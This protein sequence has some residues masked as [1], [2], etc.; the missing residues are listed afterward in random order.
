[1]AYAEIQFKHPKTGSVCSA[2]VGFSW[3]TLFFG[4]CPALLRGHYTAVIAI[5]ILTLVIVDFSANTDSQFA[6]Y[7]LWLVL[8]FIY[9]K[10]YIKH[11]LKKGYKA[12][13]ASHDLEYLSGQ[14]NLIL[15]KIQE[16]DT[17][18]GNIKSSIFEKF[19]ALAYRKEEPSLISLKEW[20][21]RV[22]DKENNSL[23]DKP[24]D[25]KYLKEICRADSG[26]TNSECLM[27][28]MAWGYT[29]PRNDTH[30]A[31]SLFENPESVEIVERIIGELRRGE[32]WYLHAY[33][34]FY[35]A[36]N[37]ELNKIKGLGVA[38][39]TKLIFFCDPKH[40]GYIMDQFASKSV[41][42]LMDTEIVLITKEG[43][44]KKENTADNYEK[45]CDTIKS[46]ASR[47][48]WKPDEVELAL[49]SD[50]G[51][52]KYVEF[53]YPIRFHK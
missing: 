4:F 6:F 44:V 37:G 25:R 34:K 18:D 48:D 32:I 10:I 35:K 39:F 40:E 2:P 31:K 13:S 51:W 1:M 43:Y 42:L 36:K 9:N 24:L 45:F 23:Y 41:N 28:I 53:E 7:I 29:N 22:F 11:L 20:Y 49:Y 19:T 50:G 30:N 46:L 38:F 15:P 5:V 26:K 33:E 16:A 8:A 27:S 52:R 17:S 3:T 12:E 47:L 21:K 14:L